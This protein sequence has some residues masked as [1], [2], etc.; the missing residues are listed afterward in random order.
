MKTEELRRAH[1]LD[2]WVIATVKTE[3]RQCVHMC[4]SARTGVKEKIK[5]YSV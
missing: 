3:S 5:K 4:M 2:N 1:K